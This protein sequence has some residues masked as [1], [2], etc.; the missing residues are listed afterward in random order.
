[1]SLTWTISPFKSTST[2]VISTTP[3]FIIEILKI[4]VSA[5]IM[6][7]IIVFKWESTGFTICITTSSE[8]LNVK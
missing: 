3:F 2:I 8:Y 5:L 1:M 7:D 6:D 4:F